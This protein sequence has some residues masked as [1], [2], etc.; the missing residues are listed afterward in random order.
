MLQNPETKKS[1]KKEFM[2]INHQNGTLRWIESNVEYQDSMADARSLAEPNPF[3]NNPCAVRFRTSH[4]RERTRRRSPLLAATPSVLPARA[5]PSR[6]KPGACRTARN[7]P[8][9]R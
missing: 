3:T 4:S 1:T 5:E 8:L 7:R 2:K 6:R 9:R